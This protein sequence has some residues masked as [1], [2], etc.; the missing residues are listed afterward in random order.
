MNKYMN[1]N[2]AGVIFSKDRAMQLE[3]TIESLFLHCGDIS[4]IELC[5]LYKTSG[6]MHGFQYNKLKEEFYNI[7]FVEEANFKEQVLDVVSGFEYVLFLVDDNLFVKD[8]YLAH[9][10]RSLQN[11]RNALA[12]PKARCKPLPQSR[13]D[14]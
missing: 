2:L 12:R 4:Q 7:S 1:N 6:E 14:G 13:G 8:F 5:V 3:G 9:I 10:L 11:N